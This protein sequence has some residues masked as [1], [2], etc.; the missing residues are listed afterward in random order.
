MYAQPKMKFQHLIL[1]LLLFSGLSEASKKKKNFK[2]K[3]N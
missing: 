1:L 2:Y 3:G